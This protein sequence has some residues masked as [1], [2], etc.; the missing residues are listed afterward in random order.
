MGFAGAFGMVFPAEAVSCVRERTEGCLSEVEDC[1]AMLRVN[2]SVEWD[3]PILTDYNAN[4]GH[5]VPPGLRRP[6]ERHMMLLFGGAYEVAV[7][8][9]NVTLGDLNFYTLYRGSS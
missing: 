6:S 1:L 7:C 9:A 3:G 2:V 5:R 8:A 4:C